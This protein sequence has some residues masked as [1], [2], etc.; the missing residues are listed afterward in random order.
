L[1]GF[2][3]RIEV[4]VPE[5]KRV[6]GYYVLPLPL[7]GRLVA[8]FDLKADRTASVLRVIAVYAEPGVDHGAV[9]AAAMAELDTLRSWLGL[10]ATLLAGKGNLAAALKAE[11][12][13]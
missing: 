1:F 13:K 2:D 11:T 4:Y 12:K 5:P 7:G 6:H 10:H 3:Y 9:A 8:R